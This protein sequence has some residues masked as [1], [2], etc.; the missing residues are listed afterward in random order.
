MKSTSVGALAVA[1]RAPLWKRACVL[2]FASWRWL[3][4]G[5]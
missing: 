3:I 2:R 5:I 4:S 1:P